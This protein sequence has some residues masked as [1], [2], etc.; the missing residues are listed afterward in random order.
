MTSKETQPWDAYWTEPR[1]AACL[2]NEEGNYSGEISSI[3]TDYFRSLASG[4]RILDIATGNGA[5]ALMALDQS[6][7]LALDFRIQAI[8]AANIDPIVALPKLAERLCRIEFLGGIQ[9]ENLPFGDDVFDA[10]C[11]QYAFEYSDLKSTVRESARVLKRGGELMFMT[12]TKDSEVFAATKSQLMD[13]EVLAGLE[14]TAKARAMLK[15]ESDSQVFELCKESF[16]K[17]AAVAME[18]LDRATGQS[19]VFISQFLK[20]LGDI[21]QVRRDEQLVASLS[22]L[23]KLEAD[24]LSH[25]LRLQSLRDAALGPE[26]IENCEATL[27]ANGFELLRSRPVADPSS[28]TILGHQFHGRVALHR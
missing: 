17:S 22:R 3:W 14:L 5:V 9:S 16:S 15:S 6:D 21:Y 27:Q 7:L 8:D 11:G 25:T 23:A 4:S 13:C 18:R 20:E 10:V 26:D 19:Q 1:L 12:H 24:L 2:R 28:N